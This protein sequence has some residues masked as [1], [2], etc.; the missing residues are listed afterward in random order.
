MDL[1][2]RVAKSGWFVL[3][4]ACLLILAAV[5]TVAGSGKAADYTGRELTKMLYAAAKDAGPDLS[6]KDLQ[7]LD[8]AGVDFKQANLAHA[9]LFGADLSQSDLSRTN[10]AEA[11]LDRTSIVAA[12]FDQADM[13]GVSLLRPTAFSDMSAAAREAPSFRGANLKGARIFAR[14]HHANFSGADLSDTYCAPFGKTGFIEVI[15]RTELLG[16]DLS[17]ATLQRSDLTHALLTFANLSRANLRSAILV[18]ADLSGANLSGAD[19]TDTDFSGADLEGTILTG[20]KGLD[21]AKGLQSAKNA[22][23]AIR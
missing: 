10:L 19:V 21:R 13:H 8:L 22:D 1:V 14:L 7:R 3:G 6:A 16:A 17:G 4:N 18:D 23:K 12:K 2:K 20:A 15:W 11:N 5:C 9:N